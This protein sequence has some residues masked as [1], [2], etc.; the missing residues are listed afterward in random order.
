M[1]CIAFWHYPSLPTLYGNV[2]Q[3]QLGF[4]PST[5]RSIHPLATSVR[6]PVAISCLFCSSEYRGEPWQ[7]MDGSLDVSVFLEIWETSWLI[8]GPLDSWGCSVYFSSCSKNKAAW[9]AVLINTIPSRGM[10]FADFFCYLIRLLHILLLW[11][12]RTH[13][14]PSVCQ[15]KNPPTRLDAVNHFPILF[16]SANIS[17]HHKETS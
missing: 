15:G 3:Q 14:L 10:C 13:S 17:K 1:F 7:G 12:S 4:T 8:G 5:P 16:I 11:L 9:M 6:S 2:I